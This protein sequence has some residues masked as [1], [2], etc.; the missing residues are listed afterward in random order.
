M[1]AIKIAILAATMAG[2]GLVATAADAR[3]Y[4]RHKV[5]QTRWVHHHKVTRCFWR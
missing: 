5:C 2:V 4:Q 3:P 1:K